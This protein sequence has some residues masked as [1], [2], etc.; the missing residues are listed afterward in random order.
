MTKLLTDTEKSPS[1]AT[2]SLMAPSKLALF[3]VLESVH[4]E[5]ISKC[6]EEPILSA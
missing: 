5:P 3:I 2:L 1:G 6:L 4:I